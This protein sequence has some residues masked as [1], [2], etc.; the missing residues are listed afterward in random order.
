MRTRGYREASRYIVRE[1]DRALGPSK[2]HRWDDIGYCVNCGE[3]YRDVSEPRR[4]SRTGHRRKADNA[5]RAPGGTGPSLA[6]RQNRA[7]AAVDRAVARALE[8]GVQF[9]SYARIKE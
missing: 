4:K 9:T 5:K 6:Y 1:C 7:I 2:R 8:L 3:A